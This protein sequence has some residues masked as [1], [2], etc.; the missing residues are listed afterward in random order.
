MQKAVKIKKEEYSRYR[1]SRKPEDYTKYKL[2]RNKT[3]CEL[4]RS[5]GQYERCL[6]KEAK[7]NPKA[8]YKYV[9]SKTKS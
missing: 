9:N 6:A 7:K 1:K 2:A 5:I 8:F 3:K 4:R